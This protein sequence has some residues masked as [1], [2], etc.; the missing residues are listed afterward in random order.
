MTKKLIPAVGYIRMS[1]GK[2]D[3]SPA[4]QKKELRK[5]AKEHG[6]KILAFYEDSGI[7]GDAKLKRTQF[8]KLI[9]DAEKGAGF[10]VVLVD[11]QDPSERYSR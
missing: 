3:K 6:D 4:Q 10:E 5:F 7:S 8:W 11:Q 2:Q 9:R 1:T